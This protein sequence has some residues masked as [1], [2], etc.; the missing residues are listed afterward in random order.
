[1]AGGKTGCGNEGGG[2]GG[3]DGN[4][5]GGVGG[6]RGGHAGKG[7]EIG[8]LDGGADGGALGGQGGSGCKLRQQWGQHVPHSEKSRTAAHRGPSASEKGDGGYGKVPLFMTKRKCGQV[9][10]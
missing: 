5:G 2:D 7:G 8:G 10:L 3:A 9:W 1:M 4:G 6:M